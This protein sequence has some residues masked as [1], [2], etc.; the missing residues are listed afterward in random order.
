MVRSI[1]LELMEIQ[2][3]DIGRPEHVNE[4]ELGV[5][6]GL[7]ELL[8]ERSG[9]SPPPWTSSIPANV[10]P[11]F[12]VCHAAK[13]PRLRQMCE[14]ESPPVLHR[15]NLFAPPNFLTFV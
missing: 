6:A 13:M 8:A 11:L 9:Q 14:T 2:L 3:V 5:A 12:L 7:L 4:I 15:R 10:E 1:A